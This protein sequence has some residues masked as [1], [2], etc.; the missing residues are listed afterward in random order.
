[1]K[2]W[3]WPLVGLDARFHRHDAADRGK[4]QAPVP[5]L[6][7]GRFSH[8]VALD[9][10]EAVPPAKH[11]AEDRM[12]HPPIQI[13]EVLLADLENPLAAAHP[14]VTK[15]V[16]HNLVNLI[17]EQ[18][19]P[20]GIGGKLACLVAVEAAA[21]RAD[22]KSLIAVLIERIHVVVREA[23]PRRSEE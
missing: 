2:D 16:L 4:P 23:I 8:P 17:A 14:E 15:V 7:S 1:N 10:G 19:L 22:P 11:G 20:G 18:S 6:P 3:R 12:D 5:G 21:P 13:V 9:A